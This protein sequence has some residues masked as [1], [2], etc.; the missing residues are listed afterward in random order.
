MLKSRGRRLAIDL[1][2]AVP[3]IVYGLTGRMM[4]F[5]ILLLGA[6]LVLRA[7]LRYWFD[8]A[9]RPSPWP[10]RLLIAC[11]S[12]AAAIGA[13]GFGRLWLRTSGYGAGV[14]LESYPTGDRIVRRVFGQNDT[15]LDWRFG[16]L[17]KR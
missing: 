8:G 12:V 9:R 3:A 16:D 5:P 13:A 7:I 2:P 1:I 17:R 4:S 14:W 15:F 10:M 11:V 6:V